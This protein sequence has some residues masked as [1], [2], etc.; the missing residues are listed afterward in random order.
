[1]ASRINDWCAAFSVDA[2]ILTD[3]SVLPHLKVS[4]SPTRRRIHVSACELQAVAQESG[5]EDLANF[6]ASSIFREGPP[7][8]VMFN[9]R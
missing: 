9:G 6:C 3:S 4:D 7:T 8:E 1:M 2:R 5:R